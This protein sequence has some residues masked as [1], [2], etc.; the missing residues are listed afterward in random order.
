MRAIAM[1][2]TDGISRG[3]D[4][5]ATGAPI[6]MPSGEKIIGRDVAEGA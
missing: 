2:T 6:K 1:E 4:V 3:I 5:L